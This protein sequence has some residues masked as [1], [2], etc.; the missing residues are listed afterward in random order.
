MYCFRTRGLTAF[1]DI[2]Q[3]KRRPA[4]VIATLTGDDLIL[5]QI[6]SQVLT[7]SYALAITNEDFITRGLNQ[8]SNV[9]PNRLFT[10]DRGLILYKA[11]QLKA[12][13]LEEVID[14]IINILQ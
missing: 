2:S 3:A 6:T 7:D 11:G 4:L 14:K 10:A 12:D 1:S 9:R 8:N 13:K 5:C